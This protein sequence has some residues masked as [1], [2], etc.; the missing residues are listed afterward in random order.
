VA[1]WRRRRETSGVEAL[2]QK[3]FRGGATERSV[4]LREACGVVIGL[5]IVLDPRARRQVRYSVM[6]ILLVT[7]AAVLAGNR[8]GR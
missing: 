4:A 2:R 6:S 8:G 7:A 3:P 5:A 1:G